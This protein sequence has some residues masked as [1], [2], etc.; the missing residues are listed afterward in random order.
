VA[1]DEVA[2]EASAVVA[3]EVSAEAVGVE[4]AEVSG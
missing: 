4:A 3:V 1:E 2:A